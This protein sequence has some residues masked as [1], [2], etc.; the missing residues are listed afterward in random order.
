MSDMDPIG[1]VVQSRKKKIKLPFGT[2]QIRSIEIALCSVHWLLVSKGF[3]EGLP[4]KTY[5]E[6]MHEKF[7]GT[8]M[9]KSLCGDH[10]KD[11][12]LYECPKEN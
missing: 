1:K 9:P 2:T 10:L 3:E 7:E 11:P 12:K 5:L 8:F 4:L 6:A